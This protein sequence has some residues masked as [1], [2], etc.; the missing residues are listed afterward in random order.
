MTTL[1][2]VAKCLVAASGACALAAGASGASAAGKTFVYGTY[3]QVMIEWDPASAYENEGIALHNMYETLTRYDAPTH[4]VLP[5]L[6]TSWSKSQGGKTWTF[7]LRKGVK[8]HTGRVF[9]AQAAKAAILRTKQIGKAAA[10]A[11]SPVTTIAT[12]NASTLVLHLKYPQP[13]DLISS[14]MYSGFMYDTQAAAGSADLGKWF[15]QGHDAGTGPYT[16]D[17]ASP[18]QETELTLK[19]F[20]DYWGG[21]SGAHYTAIAYRVVRQDS[22]AAQLA[23]SGQLDFV[24][25]INPQIWATFKGS[26][27]FQTPTSTSFQNLILYLNTA[28][29]PLADRTV[30]RAVSLGIDYNGI[31]AALKGAAVRQPG[32]IPAGLFGHTNSIP[33]YR[34]DPAG[35]KKLLASK[36]FGPGKKSI[37]L[38]VTYTQGDSNEQ[39]ITTLMKSTLA[40]L[41]INLDVQPLTTSTK[42]AKARSTKPSDRQDMTFIYWWPDFPDPATWFISLLH[43]QNPPSF[44]FAYYSNKQ[45]DK[46]IDGIEKLTATNPAKARQVYK[47]METTVH[48]DVPVI[49]LY[50]VRTQRIL[51]DSASG[52][53]EW[54]S[55]PEVVFIYNLHPKA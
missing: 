8:F 47:Q 30:R 26:P 33:L 5:L 38:R 21:W 39:T 54:P 42:Y 29:G 1:R 9:D 45:L 44:N 13:M 19:Q 14:A 15:E 27:G 41:G 11:W 4:K 53:R 49:G 36:G 6:A 12:P 17:T 52:F 25:Q 18:G 7:K 51:A 55:Y 32:I 2:W 20:P 10:Y 50:T 16:V 46:K 28:S 37:N 48:S 43:T 31:V 40:P 24:E 3:T 34:F 35:A 22:T 23:R